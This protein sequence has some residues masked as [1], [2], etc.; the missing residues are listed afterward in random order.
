MLNYRPIVTRLIVFL[1]LAAPCW[2]HA[3]PQTITVTY[4]ASVTQSF[5]GRVYVM[6]SKGRQEPRFGPSW[7]GTEPFFAKDVTD[8]KP[9]TAL[10]FDDTAVG[11]PGH[12][13]TIPSGDYSVQA[14]MRLN[15]GSP[16]IGSAAG[17]AYSSV[18]RHTFKTDAAETDATPTLALKIDQI[19]AEQPFTETDRIKLVE[20]KSELL[21]AFTGNNVTM[22]AAI[23]LPTGYDDHPD[24]RYPALYWIGGFGSDHSGARFMSRSW[25]NTGYDDQI[26]RVVLDPLCYG[27]HHVF[28]D[29]DNNGPRG[30]ALINEF[31]PHLQKTFRLHPSPHARFLSGHSSG[32]WSSL[33]LQITYPEVFGGVWSIAPDPV[34]FRDFQRIDLYKP[35]SNMYADEQGNRR[36]LA[37]NGE[38]IMAWYDDFAKMEVVYGEG[39]QL[40]SFEWVFS[41]RGDNGLPKPLYDRT[42]GLVNT[43][44]AESWKRYDIRLILEDNWK[45]LSPRLDGGARI[46]VFMGD[47]DTFYLEGATKLLKE[48]QDR[49]GSKAVIEIEPDKDHGSIATADLRKRIDRELMAEF[50]K[51]HP[52]HAPPSKE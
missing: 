28:A 16:E 35:G 24:R 10:T 29:S 7:F 12:I 25:A 47:L 34:D 4:D 15:A 27:G 36:P 2:L 37:R 5:T 21:S 30:A 18:L 51:H 33:W 20:L 26:I 22:R 6:L 19:V 43:D 42:S 31:I 17:N 49:L 46:R 11:F 3:S 9:G 23:I 48:S 14:V 44:V 1:A 32:G 50:I 52:N 45:E 39:G 8:W 13:S 38:Q 40:R 41:H